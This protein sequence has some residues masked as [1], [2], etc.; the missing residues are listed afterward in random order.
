MDVRWEEAVINE[1][2]VTASAALTRLPRS[3]LDCQLLY[4]QLL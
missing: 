4:C 2:Q 3:G 1:V